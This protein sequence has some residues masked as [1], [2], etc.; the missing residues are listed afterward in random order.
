MARKEYVLRSIEEIGATW[1]ICR[2]LML[3]R[4][5]QM[6]RTKVGVLG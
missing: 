4:S 2:V 6:P 5:C 3:H 1:G